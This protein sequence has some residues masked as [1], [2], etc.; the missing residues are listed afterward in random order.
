MEYASFLRASGKP[1]RLCL[2]GPYYSICYEWL[3]AS[4]FP[5]DQP[6]TRFLWSYVDVSLSE[7]RRTYHILLSDL[8]GSDRGA[9]T[10][11]A[12]LLVSCLFRELLITYFSNENLQWE[13]LRST[14]KA[15][16]LPERCFPPFQR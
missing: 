3:I 6:N 2:P 1:L 15:F 11:R 5:H 10:H 7:K 16:H 8:S 4:Y 14:M 13:L 12:S 9:F